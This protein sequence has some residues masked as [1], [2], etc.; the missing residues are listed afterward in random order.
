MQAFLHTAASSGRLWGRTNGPTRDLLRPFPLKRQLRFPQN[1]R[2]F[3]VAY[4]M[5]ADEVWAVDGAVS[6]PSAIQWPSDPNS[7]DFIDDS[8]EED[9]EAGIDAALADSPLSSPA[10]PDAILNKPRRPMP[11]SPPTRFSRVSRPTRSDR[12]SRDGASERIEFQADPEAIYYT[13]CGKCTAIYELKPELLG[14]GRKVCC[15]V[16]SSVWFQRPERL[17]T[18][19]KEKE[20]F[21][22]YPLDKKE[23]LMAGAAD[24]KRDNRPRMDN[25]RERDFSERRRNYGEN[26]RSDERRPSYGERQ[27]GRNGRDGRTRRGRAEFS[28]F[29]GNL[30]FNVTGDELKELLQPEFG[31]LNVTIVKDNE[32]GRSRGFAFCDVKSE[33]E[34]EKIV[35][36]FDGREL[37]GRNVVARAGRKN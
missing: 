17:L 37:Y 32:T 15:E 21:V 34:I 35:R 28:V 8:D 1:R 24:S 23:E 36:F 26:F 19:D 14:R 3:L 20:K 31:E 4:G 30:P 9:S 2:S 12:L 11:A 27:E 16:C 18:V 22:D 25:R 5:T 13:R 6:T 33:E 29:L 7:D 10:P